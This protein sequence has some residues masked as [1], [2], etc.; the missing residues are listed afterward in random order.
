MAQIVKKG[1]GAF[2]AD[3]TKI[4]LSNNAPMVARNAANS[5]DVNLFKLNASD[6]MEFSSVPQV[7]ADPSAANDLVRKSYADALTPNITAVKES[8]TL[9]GTD[10]TNQYKDL[11]NVARAST[12]MLVVN[13]VVQVEAT[14]Y[15]VNLTGGVGGKTRITF[16]GDLATAGA[17]AL[18]SGDIMHFQYLL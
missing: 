14:D 15:T 18:V 16:A 1:I 11:A 13:G 17:A 7:T 10:I 5:A 9:N 6:K 3:E 2:A 4:K 12:I 8:L